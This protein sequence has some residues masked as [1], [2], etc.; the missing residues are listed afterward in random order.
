MSHKIKINKNELE[1]L[2]RVK[3][4]T[5]LFITQ[6]YG[7]SKR[8]IHNWLGRFK[9]KKWSISERRIQNPTR[10][11]GA[12]SPTKQ[13]FSRLKMSKN[14]ADVSGKKNP[15]YNDHRF[16]GSGNPNWLGGLTD[17]GY[18]WYWNETLKNRIKKRDG[19][20]CQECGTKKR[21]EVHHIDYN[22]ENCDDNNLI[23]LCK[24]DNLKANYNRTHFKARYEQKLNRL[25]Q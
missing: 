1:Y 10:L 13:L 16:A 14:H 20:Q 2:Y 24:K 8:T 15:M 17:K 3:K 6:R 22:K 23:T 5:T 19:Y 4:V 11:C 9:I 7:C 25:I 18:P 21:L 12:C